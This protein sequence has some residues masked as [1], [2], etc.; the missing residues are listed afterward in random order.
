[1]TIKQI[2]KMAK[3]AVIEVDSGIYLKNLYPVFDICG[4]AYVHIDKIDQKIKGYIPLDLF[5]SAKTTPAQRKSIACFEVLRRK[6]EYFKVSVEL[7]KLKT[8]DFNGKSVQQ[9][10]TLCGKRAGL[11]KKITICD[12]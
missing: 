9:I 6:K 8:E 1:M 12:Y 11:T 3:W 2:G 10:L 5:I 4:S 7:C